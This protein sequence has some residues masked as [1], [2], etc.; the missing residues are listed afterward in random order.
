MTIR[1]D[2]INITITCDSCGATRSPDS[3]RWLPYPAVWKEAM[4]L[5][6]TA[7]KIDKDYA[8]DCPDCSKRAIA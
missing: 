7:R 6:W 2:K 5:G 4:T 3:N 1:R 8:H